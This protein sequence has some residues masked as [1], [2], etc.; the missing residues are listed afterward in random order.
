MCEL[1]VVYTL[2]MLLYRFQFIVR[3]V[4]IYTCVLHSARCTGTNDDGTQCD[5]D[6]S[7]GQPYCARHLQNIMHLEIK[8]SLNPAMGMG[9][10]ASNPNKGPGAVVFRREQ[11]IA[12]YTGEVLT[13]PQAQARYQGYDAPYG[14]E[15]SVGGVPRVIDAAC[16][17]GAAAMANHKS[18]DAANARFVPHQ[19]GRVTLRARKNIMNGREIFAPYG[20]N[21]RFPR[22]IEVRTEP[23]EVIDLID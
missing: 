7:V 22:Y 15:V 9:L 18:W 12:E 13:F 8:E 11:D 10:F 6:V 2:N 20:N 23:I 19:D 17:R 21:I 5:T 16:Y 4:I 3:G 1:F 14:F